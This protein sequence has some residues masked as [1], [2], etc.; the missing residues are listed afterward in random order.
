MENEVDR[1]PLT[2]LHHDIQSVLSRLVGKANQLICN[3]TTNIAESWMHIRSKF[4]TGKVVRGSIVAW[5]QV[6]RP[7]IWKMTDSSPNKVF[8]DTIEC[9]AKKL[10]SDRKK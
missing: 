1:L 5:G 2:K 10:E 4:D 6:C 7:Q 8:T 9:S 3:V